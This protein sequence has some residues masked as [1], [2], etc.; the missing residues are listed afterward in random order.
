MGEDGRVYDGGAVVKSEP[1]RFVEGLKIK[2]KV[3]GSSI[4]WSFGQ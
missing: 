1:G 4:C 2:M 3:S